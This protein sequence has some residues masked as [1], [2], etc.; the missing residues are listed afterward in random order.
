MPASFQLQLLQDSRALTCFLSQR[1]C[2]RHI[3]SVI[4]YVWRPRCVPRTLDHF[5][6]WHAVASA[7]CSSLSS[8]LV[9]SRRG[10]WLDINDLLTDKKTVKRAANASKVEMETL[11]QSFVRKHIKDKMGAAL[12]TDLSK[13]K[14]TGIYYTTVSISLI[15]LTL[16]MSCLL[17]CRIL[18]QSVFNWIGNN[19][20]KCFA[21]TLKEF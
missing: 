2:H 14:D 20:I 19:I 8:T 11:L 6:L 16:E 15:L 5:T 7:R 17:R 1:S 12:T 10:V 13:N 18:A 4:A 3:R 21:A 9:S